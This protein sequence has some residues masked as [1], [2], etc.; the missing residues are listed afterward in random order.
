[1]IPIH[2]K[3]L[4]EAFVLGVGLFMGITLTVL[5]I[6]ALVNDVTQSPHTI[7]V[8]G[9]VVLVGSVFYLYKLVNDRNVKK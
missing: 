1:M 7:I 5:G 3:D 9:L 8:L 6:N 2:K 4:F